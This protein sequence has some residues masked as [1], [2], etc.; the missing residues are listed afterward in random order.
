MAFLR[1]WILLVSSLL[2]TVL[3]SVGV[4]VVGYD[5]MTIREAEEIEEDSGKLLLNAEQWLNHVQGIEV[6]L[7]NYVLLGMEPSLVSIAENRQAAKEHIEAMKQIL[8]LYHED[9]E[10]Q[11]NGL[12]KFTDRHLR[13]VDRIIATKQAGDTPGAERA[14]ASSESQLFMYGAKLIVDNV[15]QTLQEKRRRVNGEVSLNVLRG[16]ISFALLAVLMIGVIWAS[17]AVTTRTQRHNRQLAARLEFEATHD[18]LTGLPNRRYLHDYL[19]H[20]IELAIR[21]EL[22]FALM[23]IDL[24]GFKRI[25]DTLGHEAGDR[26]L[27]EVANRFRQTSR[28]SDF[29]VRTGGDE[30]AL[31][32]ENLEQTESLRYL[33]ERLIESLAAPVELPRRALASVGCSIGIA[34]FPSSAASMDELFS[35]ADRAMYAAK[36]AGKNCWRMYEAGM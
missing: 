4:G 10:D 16:S 24:D 20:A 9:A 13:T 2:V 30:F 32:A 11:M 23:V 12:V 19:G 31:I 35:A 17:Y 27:Q 26:V 34:I 22:H 7:R 33:A 36:A 3:M 25:N 8:V 14:L 21:H 29:I 5:A 18:A 1:K 28:G 6:A 15:T